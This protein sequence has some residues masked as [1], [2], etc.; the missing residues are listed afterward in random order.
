MAHARMPETTNPFAPKEPLERLLFASPSVGIGTFRCAAEDPRFSDTGP[1]STY[2]FAFPRTSVWI[3][4]AGRAPFVADPGTVSYYNAGQEYS[5]RKL[6]PDGDRAEWFAVAPQIAEEIIA[7]VAPASTRGGDAVFGFTHGPSDPATYLVQRRICDR[8]AGGA[9]VEA[10]EIEEQV[11]EL[12]ATLAPR[13]A[14][15]SRAAAVEL[16]R[17]KRLLTEDARALLALT[18]TENVHLA[19]IARRLSCSVFHLCRVFKEVHGTTLHAY[20]LDVRLRMA[21]E[22]VVVSPDDLTAI[23][24]DLG[25]CSHSH[26]TAAFRR[27]FGRTPS[28]FLAEQKNGSGVC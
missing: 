21:L 13:A 18:A 1:S 28:A 5:R 19:E 6:S 4:H 2:C 20:R 16:T 23:A 24:L 22:R 10:L 17:R 8:L 7:A 11:I 26:F 25:F 15:C 3:R 27:Q 12:L 14:E 9:A